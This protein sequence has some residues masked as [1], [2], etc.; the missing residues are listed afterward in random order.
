MKRVSKIFAVIAAV[1]LSI[2]FVTGC[3][4]EWEIKKASKGLTT[5]YID[6]VFCDAEKKVTAV[7]TVEYINNTNTILTNV[8]FNLYGKAFSETATIK[9]YSKSKQEECFPNGVNYGDMVVSSVS[10]D[11]KA[12]ESIFV[13]DDLNALQVNLG[14][15]LYSGDKVNIIICFEVFLANCEHRLGYNAGKVNL[16]NWYPVVAVYENGSFD[17][18]P[19]Y[20][21]G[22]P[23]YSECANYNV[24]ISYADKYTLSSTGEKLDESIES[25]VKQ[26][27]FK[28]RA[29]RDFAM[30]MLE[31]CQTQEVA[32]EDTTV[33]VITKSGDNNISI[34]L[35]T[36]RRSVELF[37]RLFGKYPYSKL[38]VVFTDFFQGGMEYPNLVYI[39][40]SVQE[41]D[42]IKKVIVHE[43]AHQWWY[44]LVGNDEVSVAWFDEGLAE[45]ST[46]L[47][48]ENYPDEGVD[49]K[50]MVADTLTNYELY[51]DVIKSLKLEINYGME[52]ALNQYKT[53][54]E[55]V[56]MIYVKGLLF[57][58]AL[59]NSVGDETFFDCLK[60]IYK[61]YKFKI[62]TK[63]KFIASIENTSGLDITEFV[64]GWLSGN[65]DIS[66]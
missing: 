11:G 42:E 60:D 23:F 16:G 59:R 13:G 66:H 34:Y 5:Y 21:N 26:S 35:E 43:I 49:A 1:F 33:E 9:P 8:C 12:A 41:L 17:I 4:S 61:N 45:Y 32:V 14:K 24:T 62:I 57:F 53:E 38:A 40:N 27:S 63:E 47:Y 48:Y 52:L 54:Y 3:S 39:S 37:N 2:F 56:Y 51:L 7:Q 18:A 15:E 58:D 22:D 64:E 44:G 20:A 65:F 19:Y 29:V 31:D 46:L 55:Y 28:A 50:K 36:A 10:V 6:A 30:V 25:G